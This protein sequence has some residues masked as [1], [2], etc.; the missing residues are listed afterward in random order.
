M[1]ITYAPTQLNKGIRS[2]FFKHVAGENTSFVDKIAMRIQSSFSNEEYGWL[3]ESPQMEEIEDE[4]EFQPPTD[5][6]Y[7]LTNRDYASGLAFKRRQV[8][9]EQSGGIAMR[10]RQLAQVAASHPNKLLIQSLIDG[11]SA[12]LGVDYTGE[13]FFNAAHSARGQQTA[14]QSNIQTGTGT[15]TA[16]V[17][18]DLN[19]ALAALLDTLGENDEP[20][21]EDLTKI[22][23]GAPPALMKPLKE[24]VR[25][26][27]IDQTSNVQFEGMAFDFIFTARL[28]A[29][30]AND[31]YVMDTGNPTKGLVF[32]DREPLEFI[33]LDRPDD[34]A[35]FT[36]EVYRYKARATYASGYGLWQYIQKVTN[37]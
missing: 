2:D 9:D 10:T 37:T 16:Q 1:G 34:E 22:T 30:D 32:Q 7:T 15:T 17:A 6:S 19:T 3:G 33:A 26:Q 18:A 20:F 14:T 25:A 24:A 23:V 28:T 29:D 8:K 21:R 12:T 35:A 31:Y 11:D 4:I 13:A 27:I 5:T 36:R